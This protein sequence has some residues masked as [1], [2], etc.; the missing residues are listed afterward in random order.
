MKINFRIFFGCLVVVAFLTGVSYLAAFAHDEG[1][2][3]AAIPFML[4]RFPTHTLFW[5]YFSQSSYRYTLGPWINIFLNAF[6]LERAFAAVRSLMR[7]KS[8]Q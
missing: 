8:T 4:F 3:G 7:R 2:G 6:L 5:D 1:A